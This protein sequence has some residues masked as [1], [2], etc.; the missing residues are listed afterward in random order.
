MKEQI[1][2]IN[3]I[4]IKRRFFIFLIAITSLCFSSCKKYLDEKP[5]KKLSTPSTIEDL[6]AMLDNY[7]TLNT[8]Y[9]SAGEISS[10]NY[11]LP[12]ASWAS[13]I[14]RHR[15]YYLWQ[16]Y[17]DIGGDWS[18]PY[19]NIFYANII[20]ET[21]D[22]IQS[23]NQAEKDQL[24]GSALFIRGFNHFSLSQLFAPPYDANTSTKDLGIP[25]RLHSDITLIPVRSTVSETYNSILSDLKN[26]VPLL[27]VNPVLKYHPSRPAAYALLARVYL[28][29]GEYD[30]AGLYSDS[31][32]QLYNILMDYNGIN[33]SATIPFKQ[34]NDEVIYDARTGS[35]AALVSSKARVDTTLYSSYN[36]NDLRRTI[37]FKSN[38]N[39]S[40]AFKGNYTGIS[41]AS[42]FVGLATDEV[43]L[44]RAESFARQGNTAAAIDDLNTLMIN[45][46]KAGTFTPFA[47]NDATE[48]L[49]VILKERRKELLYRTLRWSDLRRL[50]KESNFADTLYRYINGQEY[51]LLPGSQRYTFQIDR[52]AINISG[53]QQNP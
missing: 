26:A 12:D 21:L 4:D 10:D 46:W 17:D 42:L 40:K 33:A 14:E 49:R 32:L 24:K 43:Y 37:Y 52:Q 48:T 30:K 22:K 36:T 45:R 31:C 38:S 13:I 39:G 1:N 34:F 15:N 8:R 18:S 11:Y 35:P 28:T 6:E 5:D 44:I 23:H 29:M 16:K 19:N 3:F 41:S 50:N 7:S 9:P 2:K 51:Q 25:I 27:P 20:L 47:S 53:L